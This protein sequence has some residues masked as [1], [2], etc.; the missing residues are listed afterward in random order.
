MTDNTKS[1]SARR[2]QQKKANKKGKPKRNVWK[3]IMMS[4]L[5]VGVVMIVAGIVTFFAMIKDAPELDDKM[6]KDPLS[7]TIITSDNEEITLQGAERRTAVDIQEVPEHVQSA[8]IAIEDVRFREHHGIDPKRIFGAVIANVKEGYGSEGASTITQ[9]VIKLS[10]LTPE[11][12]IKRKV[13]EQYLAVQLEQNYSK[14]QILEMYMNKI[15]FSQ[16]AYGVETA[17]KTYFNKSAKELTIDEAALLA[18]IPQRP[19]YYDPVQNPDAAKERRDIVIS[20][21]EKYGFITS[22][23]A[24]EATAKPIQVEQPKEQALKYDAFISQVIQELEETK[25]ID[26]NDIYNGGLKIYTTLNTKAQDTLEQI[27]NTEEYVNYP[28]EQLQAGVTLLDTKTGAVLALGGGRHQEKISRGLNHA[29]QIKRQPGSTA[30]PVLAYGPAI[31]YLKWPTAK[32]VK[33]EPYQ[34]SSGKKLNNW[35]NSYAGDI[36]IRE[37]LRK[38]L[39]I[40]AVKT[41][42]KVGVANVRTFAEGLGV[43]LDDGLSERY[44]IGGFDTGIAPIHLAGAYAAF[45]NNGVYNKPHTVSKIVY[46]DGQELNLTPESE[47]AMHDYTAYMITD[48]LK[49]VVRSG[50]GTRANISGLPMAGKTGTTNFE[51]R[52]GF[53]KDAVRDAWFAGYTT[54]YTIAVWTGYDKATKTKY[55]TDKTGSRI[56]QQIFKSLMT[57][58]SKGEKTPDF[59]QPKSVV[60]VTVNKSTGLRAGEGTPEDLLTSELFIRGTVPKEITPAPNKELTAPAVKAEYD[61]TTKQVNVSWAYEGE[62]KGFKVKQSVNGQETETV[63]TDVS[64]TIPN[65]IPD[66]TYTFTVIAID[67]ETEKDSPAGT[68]SI[69][70]PNEEKEKEEQKKLEEEQKRLEE[71]QLKE[72]QKRLEEEQ[73]KLEKEQN[74]QEQPEPTAPAPAPAPQAPT[75]STNKQ[76]VPQPSTN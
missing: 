17:A 22:N 55:L 72:E 62:I 30:K 68:A 2:A 51:D 58:I 18:G 23:E 46:P 48:M 73:K 33:D 41:F 50:T 9:Q 37:S 36:T 69:K 1:R 34:Y 43:P 32:I 8:F 60:R 70:I 75:P 65:A 42:E 35:N 39:N 6:L 66:A 20:Q 3:K 63:T 67:K 21:M 71:E 44:A 56:S 54:N 38:S 49:D 19:S 5:L 24:H 47:Q 13:Q 40:P 29:T 15:Y 59:T 64:F 74:Q 61:A 4:I 7:S 26:K 10:F 25:E 14:D 31:E 53:P 27:L 45:G 11:K 57:E 12:T 16:G 28:D 76:P 52:F